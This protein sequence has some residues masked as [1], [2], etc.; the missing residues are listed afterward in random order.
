MIKSSEKTTRQVFVAW[1]AVLFYAGLI[2]YSS[3]LPK[4]IPF[5]EKELYPPDWVLHMA[6]YS[7]FG[8]LVARAL[9]VSSR[10][11]S[12]FLLLAVTLLIGILYG[13]SDEW[14]Q[15]FVPQRD[16]SIYDVIADGIGALGGAFIWLWVKIK[17]IK[18]ER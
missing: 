1:A 17:M 13:L 16:S 18:K 8:L 11:F 4:P 2:F 9:L 5:I 12:R 10:G 14:H 7:V 15:S 3:S 6:E